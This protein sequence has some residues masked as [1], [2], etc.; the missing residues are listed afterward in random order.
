MKEEASVRM[1]H[2]E[3]IVR[4]LEERQH[5]GAMVIIGDHHS[6]SSVIIMGDHQ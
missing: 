1:H 2:G 4:Y 6:Y 5:G 3:S